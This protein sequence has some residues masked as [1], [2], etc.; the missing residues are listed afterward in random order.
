MKVSIVMLG[1][2]NGLVYT[3]HV[4]AAPY[5]TYC[6][7]SALLAVYVL[8]L[9]RTYCTSYTATGYNMAFN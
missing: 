9:A 5:G 3:V 2:L 1:W 7:L 6:G 8:I 4:C